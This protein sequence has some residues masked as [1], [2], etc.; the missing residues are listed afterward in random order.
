MANRKES[1]GLIMLPLLT[2]EQTHRVVKL[3]KDGYL[4]TAFIVHAAIQGPHKREINMD[5]VMS[6]VLGVAITLAVVVTCLDI[7][8]WRP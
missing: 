5:T 7:T 6:Y 2:N 3:S 4:T 8:I 1:E